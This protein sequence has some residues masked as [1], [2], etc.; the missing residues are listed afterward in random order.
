MKPIES[1]EEISA[2][3]FGFMASKALFASL[4]IDIFGA[5]ACGAKSVEELAA[6]TKAPPIAS[7]PWSPPWCRLVY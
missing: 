4:H 3:A 5:L 7:R 6:G 2:L 1:A